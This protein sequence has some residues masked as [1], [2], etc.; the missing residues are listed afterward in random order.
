MKLTL[1]CDCGNAEMITI[2]PAR[3][4]DDA[5][6][7]D[8]IYINDFQI[9]GKKFYHYQSYPDVSE[10]TCSNCNKSINLNI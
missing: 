4:A 5:E 2:N 9:K 1:T 10:I 7:E 6:T 3:M 8:S